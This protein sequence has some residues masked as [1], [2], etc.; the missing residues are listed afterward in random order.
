MALAINLTRTGTIGITSSSVANPSVITTTDPH[1]LITDDYTTIAGHSGSTPDINASWQVTVT[2]ASTFTIS[3]NVTVGGTGGTSTGP[4]TF[5]LAASNIVISHV[6]APIVAPL[7]GSDPLI[8]DLGQ[9]KTTVTVTGRA[10]F[11]GTNKLD[12]TIPIA[13]RDDFENMVDPLIG[14]PWFDET[15][16]LT[17]NTDSG[18]TTYTVKI[19]TV[20]LEKIDVKK[21]YEFTIS[22]IGFLVA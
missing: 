13:D 9:W 12:G 15:I 1:G 6:R 11:T 5:N 7:P 2:G 3:V 20:K 14:N 16:T 21:Y 18:G 4:H 19:S 8:L 17:D 10:E 22:C